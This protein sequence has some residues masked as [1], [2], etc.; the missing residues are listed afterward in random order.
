MRLPV[1]RGADIS[2]LRDDPILGLPDVAFW[3]TDSGQRKLKF[4]AYGLDKSWFDGLD[5][6]VSV[7]EFIDEVWQARVE[8][9]VNDRYRR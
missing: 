3:V 1:E 5:Y 8:I 6:V 2:A 4:T 9:P 7:L